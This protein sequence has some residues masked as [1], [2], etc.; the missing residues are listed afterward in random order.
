MAEPA[1][2]T[3]SPVLGLIK[4]YDTPDGSTVPWTRPR[5]VHLH[6]K[7]ASGKII[8]CAS[9]SAGGIIE[10]P[11]GTLFF[12]ASDRLVPEEDCRHT[13]T[14]DEKCTCIGNINHTD[15]KLHYS[16]IAIDENVADSRDI[17]EAKRNQIPISGQHSYTAVLHPVLIKH[18]LMRSDIVVLARTRHNEVIK[19][20]ITDMPSKTAR[21][22]Y[23]G[24]DQLIV[25]QFES[26]PAL[27]LG[28]MDVGMWVYTRRDYG[29]DPE[30]NEK[31]KGLHNGPYPSSMF[32]HIPNTISPPTPPPESSV[33][34]RTSL[35]GTIGEPQSNS[36]TV[37]AQPSPANHPFILI[38]HIVELR[39]RTRTQDKEGL[40]EVAIQSLYD[41]LTERFVQRGNLNRSGN[42]GSVS[43]GVENLSHNNDFYYQ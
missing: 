38:G 26:S 22:S 2:L 31:L 5:R 16:L 28:R 32:R 11:R 39:G 9:A 25:A 42:V 34:S 21:P 8:C 27:T 12:L 14:S 13:N 4:V 29:D 33:S 20:Y 19:G 1:N 37:H 36:S 17:D 6:E 24:S 7:T 3:S 40:V 30:A 23:L 41:V 10:D 35:Q 43:E 18:Q 15:R